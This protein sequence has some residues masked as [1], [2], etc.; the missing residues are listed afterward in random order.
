MTRPLLHRDDPERTP[1]IGN[2]KVTREDWLAHARDVLVRDGVAHVKILPLAGRMGVSRSSFYWFFKHRQELLDALL[3]QWQAKNTGALVAQSELPAPTIT[4]AVCNVQRCVVDPELY[5]TKLDF[6]VRDWARQSDKVRKLLRA[7]DAT[8]IAALTAMFRRYDYD[9]A[10]AET[11]AFTLY[12]MQIGYDLADL[13]EPIEVRLG[14]FS[15]YLHVFTGR[16][17]RPE[18]VAEFTAFARQ[19]WERRERA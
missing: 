1:L 19:H 2:Q 10:E 7:S 17:P 13:E 16:T 6:A 11:R 5:E 9:A 12:Y 18:E 8:R 3:A 14:R 4:A 15:E